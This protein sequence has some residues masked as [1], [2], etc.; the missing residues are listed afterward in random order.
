MVNIGNGGGGGRKSS[1]DKLDCSASFSNTDQST[2][3]SVFSKVTSSIVGDSGS[4]HTCPIR[5]SL[6]DLDVRDPFFALNRENDPVDEVDEAFDLADEYTELLA[7]LLLPME[8]RTRYDPGR[9]VLV[10]EYE[11]NDWYDFESPV[12][13]NPSDE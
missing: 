10:D 3:N 4:D 12:I 11:P 7:R 13:V 2:S 5:L 8:G 6:L 9:G 1:A